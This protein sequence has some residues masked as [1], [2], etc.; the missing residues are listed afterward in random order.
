MY[1]VSL[2][3]CASKYLNKVGECNILCCQSQGVFF[4]TYGEQGNYFLS[5]IIQITACPLKKKTKI[6]LINT[7]QLC[8]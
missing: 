8:F 4:D 2:Y 3:I 1:P 6:I 5:K 7:T